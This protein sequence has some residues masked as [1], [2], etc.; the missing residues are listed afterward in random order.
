MAR[1]FLLQQASGLSSPGNNDSKQSASAVQVR[2][3]APSGLGSLGWT[4]VRLEGG[5]GKPRKGKDQLE[6]CSGQSP[7]PESGQREMQPL[8]GVE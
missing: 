6:N 5:L 4:R 8:L 7:V 1:Q 3:R 2:R